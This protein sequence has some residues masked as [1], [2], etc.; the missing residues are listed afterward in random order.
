MVDFDGESHM[1]IS[2]SIFL[3]IRVLI[4]GRRRD[5]IHNDVTS[6]CQSSGR[7]DDQAQWAD[8]F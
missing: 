1:K 7:K 5:A 6:W 2:T 8:F 3:E 4:G